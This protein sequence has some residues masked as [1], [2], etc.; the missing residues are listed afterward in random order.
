MPLHLLHSPCYIERT[1][2]LCSNSAHIDSNR[3]D[4]AW[5]RPDAFSL[6]FLFVCLVS[7]PVNSRLCAAEEPPLAV[8][9]C[10]IPC[11]HRCLLSQW[12][13]WGA[14]LHDNCKEPQGKRGTMQW[15][16][17]KTGQSLQVPPEMSSKEQSVLKDTFHALKAGRALPY[18]WW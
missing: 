3:T 14:C 13:P 11:Q 15:T 5:F 18:E 4:T 12:S 7:R 1:L 2:C 10:S 6:L 16:G 8:Q 9:P 17:N